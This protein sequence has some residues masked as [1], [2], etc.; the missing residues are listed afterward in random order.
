MNKHGTTQTEK[1][2]SV[3]KFEDTFFTLKMNKS[4]GYDDI[5]FNIVKKC[6]GVLHKP[7][8]YLFNLCYL[9]YCKSRVGKNKFTLFHKNSFKIEIAL[10]LF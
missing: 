10:K 7:L 4:A 9:F 3:N 8:L 1:L 2:I 6:F 5:S